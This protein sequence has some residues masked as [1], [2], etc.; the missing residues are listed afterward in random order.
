MI[1]F[2]PYSYCQNCVKSDITVI[3][4]KGNEL[5]SCMSPD[6]DGKIFT[7]VEKGANEACCE[8]FT[9]RFINYCINYSLCQQGTCTLIICNLF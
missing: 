1:A 8:A 7:Y 6:R 9:G 5:G 3:D 2:V 4:E